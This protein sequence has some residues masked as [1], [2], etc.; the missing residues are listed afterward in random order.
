[1]MLG[2]RTT[3]WGPYEDSIL[4]YPKK[5]AFG[6]LVTSIILA[7]PACDLYDFLVRQQRITLHLQ[8]VR[9]TQLSTLKSRPSTLKPSRPFLL[10]S[11]AIC[12]QKPPNQH[13]DPQTSY[14]PE[15][16]SP[17]F[18]SIVNSEIKTQST[19]RLFSCDSIHNSMFSLLCAKLYPDDVFPCHCAQKAVRQ[20]WLEYG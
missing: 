9:V 20:Q 7:W 10:P 19:T 3:I 15:G 14:R 17:G 1:M 13:E 6:Q 5:P 4:A 12:T 11:P 2:W 18:I 16:R 8:V